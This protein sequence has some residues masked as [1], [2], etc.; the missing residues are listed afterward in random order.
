[1][2]TS[3][4]QRFRALRSGV[5]VFRASEHKHLLCTDLLLNGLRL[6]QTLVFPECKNLF[7]QTSSFNYCLHRILQRLAYWCFSKMFF[8]YTSGYELRFASLC[9]SRLKTFPVRLA[10]SFRCTDLRFTT[11]PA[12]RTYTLLA[13]CCYCLSTEVIQ[14]SYPGSKLSGSSR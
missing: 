9:S 12:I 13:V 10:L 1:M 6:L 7:L 11:T 5:P 14:F 4:R 3:S 2:I 8:V